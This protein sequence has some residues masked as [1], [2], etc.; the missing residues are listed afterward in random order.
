VGRITAI[1]TTLIAGI[2]LLLRG[3]AFWMPRA[4]LPLPYPAHSPSTA[5][6][7]ALLSTGCGLL[8]LTSALLFVTGRRSAWMLLALAALATTVLSTLA[9]WQS[10]V[11]DWSGMA[12][13]FILCLVAALPHVRESALA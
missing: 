12:A 11:A 7:F 8:L 5:L 2:W 13:A 4:F 6:L 3:A 1:V 9:W 10:G